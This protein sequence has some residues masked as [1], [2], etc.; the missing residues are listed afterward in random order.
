MHFNNNNEK[1]L[2]NCICFRIVEIETVIL[3]FIQ[4]PH[5]PD[6]LAYEVVSGALAVLVHLLRLRI[7]TAAVSEHDGQLVVV[8][9]LDLLVLPADSIDAVP[10]PRVDLLLLGGAPGVTVLVV[11]DVNF[12]SDVDLTGIGE[13]EAERKDG[14]DYVL[15]KLHC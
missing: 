9:F 13:D 2:N 4:L 14:K 10:C 8:H 5:P 12:A 3:L 11:G 15:D 7:T 6:V 1:K